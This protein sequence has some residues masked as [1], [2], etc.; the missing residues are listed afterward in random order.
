MFV[1]VVRQLYSQLEFDMPHGGAERQRSVKITFSLNEE[2][3]FVK[4]GDVMMIKDKNVS[5]PFPPSRSEGISCVATPAL[6]L[7]LQ[8]VSICCSHVEPPRQIGTSFSSTTSCSCASHP[9]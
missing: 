1:F 6:L 2:R 8:V 9:P 5:K 7:L 3:R 4:E